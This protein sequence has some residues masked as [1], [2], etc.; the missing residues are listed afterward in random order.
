MKGNISFKD[1]TFYYSE[2]APVLKD[3]SFQINAG[4]FVGVIG[5]SGAGK[6]TIL[7]LIFRLFDPLKG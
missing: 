5:E 3:F 7:N 4:D 1:V 6:S 2:I